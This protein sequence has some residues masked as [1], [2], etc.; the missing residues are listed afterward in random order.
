MM[1]EEIPGAERGGAGDERE[2]NES[3]KTETGYSVHRTLA[4]SVLPQRMLS[5]RPKAIPA[6]ALSRAVL[7]ASSRPGP[8]AERQDF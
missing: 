6:Q 8:L 3:G 1:T 2:E 7:V 5:S 4:G